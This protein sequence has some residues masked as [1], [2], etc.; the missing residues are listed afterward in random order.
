MDNMSHL[1]RL[2]G[3]LFIAALGYALL[4]AMVSFDFDTV[5][6]RVLVSIL[7]LGVFLYAGWDFRRIL[8]EIGFKWPGD[9]DDG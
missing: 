8:A 6:E 3:R 9:D 2:L 1:L 4:F 7:F 5:E